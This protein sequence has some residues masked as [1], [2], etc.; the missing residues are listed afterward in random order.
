M[1]SGRLDPA[2]LTDKLAVRV[3]VDVVF[4]Q[5]VTVTT[6]TAYF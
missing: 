1:F 6:L 2:L 4:G 3:L 5:Q